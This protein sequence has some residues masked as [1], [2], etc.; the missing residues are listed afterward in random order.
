MAGE[1]LLIAFMFLWAV[2]AV[3]V[4]QHAE[5]NGHTGALWAIVTF[6]FGLFGLALY[7]IVHVVSND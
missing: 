3:F 1:L 6:L 2:V 7:G 5:D 4:Y